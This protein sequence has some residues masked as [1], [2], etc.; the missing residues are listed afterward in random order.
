LQGLVPRR[1][2]VIDV[3]LMADA[4]NDGVMNS[5]PSLHEFLLASREEVLFLDQLIAVLRADKGEGVAGHQS[6]GESAALHGGDLLRMGVTVGQVVQDYGSI[7]QSVTELADERQANITA[8]EFQ[9]FNSCLDD[10]IARAVTGHQRQRDIAIERSGAGHVTALA[11]E[12]RNLLTT[13]MLTFDAL[14]RGRIGVNGSTGTLLGRT[15]RRMRVAVDRTLAEVRLAAGSPTSE[16][17]MI[18]ELMEEI[19]IAGTIEAVDRDVALSVELGAHD[20]AVRGDHQILASAVANLVQNA[21]KFTRPHGHVRVCARTNG[22]RVLIEIHDECGGL[23][24]GKPE[25]LF[26]PFQP[27]ASEQSGLGLGL[28]SSLKGVHANGGEL[29]ALDRPGRGCTFTITLPRA[30]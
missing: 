27:R 5:R 14:A 4:R 23:P 29:E 22:T 17:V 26:R 30:P 8:A 7:C 10:A 9:I 28:S 19:E 3:T 25:A 6:L 16:R 12:V 20:V 24:P 13:S 18:A 21:V 15:L 11:H 1:Q 2:R